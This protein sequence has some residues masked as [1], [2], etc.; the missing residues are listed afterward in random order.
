MRH[1]SPKTL[2]HDPSP[3]SKT[4]AIIQ[5]S[6]DNFAGIYPEVVAT[7]LE[8]AEEKKLMWRLMK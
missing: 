7:M 4:Q 8:H 6:V 2:L 1:L 3:S 5:V